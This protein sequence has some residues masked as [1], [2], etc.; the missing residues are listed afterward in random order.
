MSFSATRRGVEEYLPPTFLNTSLVVWERDRK[1]HRVHDAR[2][3]GNQFNPTASGNARFS[4]IRDVSGTLIPTLY[5]GTSLDCALMET[6]F[7]DLP[8]RSGFKP[9][10]KKKI[11]GKVHSIVLPRIDLTL[12]DLS[13]IAL[14]KLGIDRV[15]LIDT[16]KAQYPRTRSWA[17]ALY[18]Q[19]QTAHG[20]SWTS[21]RH[22]QEQAVLLFGFRVSTSDLEIL[23]PSLPLLGDPNSF[24]ALIGLANRLGATLVE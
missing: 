3:L 1:M 7:H 15:H 19:V 6:I 13:S 12:I 17:E 21:R 4:P 5:A 14:H 9:V 10:S 18:T 11:A 2:Y 24:I 16:T 20:L 22:D 23:G 8:Y